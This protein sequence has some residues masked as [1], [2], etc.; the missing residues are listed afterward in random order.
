MKPARWLV[1]F[2]AFLMLGLGGCGTLGPLAPVCTARGAAPLFPHTVNWDR[3]FEIEWAGLPGRPVVEGY[4]TNTWGFPAGRIQLLV[5]GLDAEGRL[6]G[7]C[8]GW[9]GLPLQ[10]GQ[11]GYFTAPA[12]PGALAYRVRVMAFDWVQTGNDDFL[13]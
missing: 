13:H 3:Y 6:T 2:L 11:R 12:P 10:P 8:I 1:L 9:F 5:D 4:L 7:Q